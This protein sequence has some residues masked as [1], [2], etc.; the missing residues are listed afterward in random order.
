[1]L[2]ADRFTEHFLVIGAMTQTLKFISAPMTLY[3]DAM[4]HSIIGAFL[5]AIYCSALVCLKFDFAEQAYFYHDL[6][7]PQNP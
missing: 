2:N 7:I 6:I 4:L 1:L 5:S 3:V